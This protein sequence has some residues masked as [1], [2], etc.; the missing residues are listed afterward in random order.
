MIIPYERGS[1]IR[2][3]RFSEKRDVTSA[4]LPARLWELERSQRHAVLAL[5]FDLEELRQ[6][7][8]THH[9][10]PVECADP[11]S[12]GV[13]ASRC[14]CKDAFSQALQN[15][16]D[17]R[18]ALWLGRFAKM[19]S[20]VAALDAWRAALERGERAGALWGLL[21]CRAATPGLRRTVVED[22]RA[23]A[24]LALGLDPTRRA[25]PAAVKLEA[26]A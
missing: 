17:R 24:L 1:V 7:V 8:L 21:T 18:Y 5:C 6:L 15:L 16:L 2:A 26:A 4:I 9:Q 10:I 13:L 3:P 25:A 20:E 19:E 14:G 11:W 12:A 23:I 22:V